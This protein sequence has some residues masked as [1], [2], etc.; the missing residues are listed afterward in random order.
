MPSFMKRSA[1]TFEREA[2]AAAADAAV[3]AQSARP[4][5]LGAATWF[6]TARRNAMPSFMQRSASTFD[7]EAAAA[8][9]DAATESQPARSASL[10][11]VTWFASASRKA[12][13]SFMKRSAST[14]DREAV[15]AATDA[16]AESAPQAPEKLTR[17]LSGPAGAW[18]TLRQKFGGSA[19]DIPR[20]SG[21][22][23][24]MPEGSTAAT[25]EP[26]E[27]GVEAWR[28]STLP[29]LR[30]SLDVVVNVDNA[31]PGAAITPRQ[32]PRHGL[33]I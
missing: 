2:A 26:D 25:G 9:A 30:P 12:M 16:A 4:T 29:T 28:S 11:A 10:G 27:S 18:T 13:P 20:P 1:S 19:R 15:A 8:A 5:S 21:F 17:R 22:G 6:A 23:P 14:F 33:P 32:S 24:A 31:A 7:R 3:E